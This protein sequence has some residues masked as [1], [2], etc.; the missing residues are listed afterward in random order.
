V[1]KLKVLFATVAVLALCA[2]FATAQT[3]VPTVGV[4]AAPSS[5]ALTPSGS[6]APGPTRFRVTRTGRRDVEFTLVTLRAGVSVSDLRATLARSQDAALSLVFVEADM[7]LSGPT[8][9]KSVTLSLRANVTYVAV[10]GSGRRSGLATFRTTGTPNGAARPAADATIRMVD[11]GFR[12]PGTLPRNG[13]IRV[14]N[15]GTA[16]HFAVA[17][18]LRPGVSGRRAGTALRTNDEKGFNR[19]VAGPPVDVQ[20]VISPGTTTDNPV[21]FARSGR[22]VLVCFFGEHNR[23]GMYRVF[24]VRDPVGRG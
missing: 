6:I 23:L 20:G 24:R 1:P 14:A 3:S 11:Y 16:F 2:A 13:T 12:G 9:T 4:S 21:R 8:T 7:S 18:P 19:L 10:S 5:V 15:R 22:V 17:F